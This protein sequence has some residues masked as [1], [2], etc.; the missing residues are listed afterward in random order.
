[1]LL[2][3]RPER[4]RGR[5]VSLISLATLWIAQLQAS[6]RDIVEG[7]HYAGQ[8]RNVR[9]YEVLMDLQYTNSADLCF[10]YPLKL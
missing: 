1:M 2:S 4:G 6:L 7:H 5:A 10:I 9:C 3:H 8:Q